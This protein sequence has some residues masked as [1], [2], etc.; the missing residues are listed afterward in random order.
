MATYIAQTRTNY[1]RV[2]DGDAFEAWCER[3]N[4]DVWTKDGDKS[5]YAFSSESEGG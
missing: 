1:F 5:R 4:L 2:T 3:R